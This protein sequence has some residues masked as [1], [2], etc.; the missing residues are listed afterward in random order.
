[1]SVQ[2]ALFQRCL[3]QSPKNVKSQHDIIK[4]MQQSGKF[5]MNVQ[6]PLLNVLVDE[7]VRNAHK[8]GRGGSALLWLCPINVTTCSLFY[9]EIFGLV[10]DNRFKFVMM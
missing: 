6:E 1:M 7:L 2:V 4:T 10:I 3:F 5:C 8:V 9:C